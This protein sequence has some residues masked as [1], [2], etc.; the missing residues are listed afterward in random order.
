MIT[1]FLTEKDYD[2]RVDCH[3]RACFV[4]SDIPFWNLQLGAHR[5]ERDSHD[6]HDCEN[7]RLC[8]HRL[9]R[10]IMCV[11]EINVDHSLVYNT[12]L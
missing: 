10:V 9:L 12:L 2:G 11:C 3:P 7:L 5:N 6:W 4:L 1:S 8:A